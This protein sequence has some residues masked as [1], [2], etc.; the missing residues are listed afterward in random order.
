MDAFVQLFG[1]IPLST[2]ITFIVAVVFFGALTVKVYKFITSTHD[3]FQS[4]EKAFAVLKKDMEEIKEKQIVT[5]EEWTELKEEQKNLKKMLEEVLE[6]QKTILNRQE[7]FETE[8][9]SRNLNKLRDNLLQ[10]YRYYANEIKNPMQ[11]WT[12]MEQEAF[13]KLFRDYEDL[14]GDGFMHST[15]E[16]AMSELEVIRMSD[17]EGVTELMKSRKG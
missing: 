13:M 9:K 17:Q 1:G 6:T 7:K 10:S 12:E 4:K 15:V 2:V 16:P 14:G 11:A 3:E 5:K 8:E